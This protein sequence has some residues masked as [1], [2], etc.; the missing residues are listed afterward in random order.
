MIERQY[1]KI[2]LICDTC[3][4]YFGDD[5]TSDE[6][7]DLL[8]DAKSDGWRTFR[9]DHEEWEHKCGVCMEEQRYGTPGSSDLIDEGDHGPMNDLSW[10]TGM[11]K[12]TR[13]A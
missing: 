5:Y 3:G 9:N 7:R 10:I 11:G 1:G 13:G 4:D 12:G 2:S 8:N 6:F